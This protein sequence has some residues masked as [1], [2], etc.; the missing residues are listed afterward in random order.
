MSNKQHQ[1][2][3][4][5]SEMDKI[6][7]YLSNRKDIKLDKPEDQVVVDYKHVTANREIWTKWTGRPKNETKAEY[8]DNS[9]DK[10]IQTLA[11]DIKNNASAAKYRIQKFDVQRGDPI[12]AK[13]EYSFNQEKTEM[14]IKISKPSGL[15][16]IAM[17]GTYQ[18]TLE[19]IFY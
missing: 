7:T 15:S 1:F 13:L 16:E 2:T 17:K 11:E 14:N 4:Q 12:P 5:N 9:L 18:D 10:F 19:L 3:I 8:S 6:L